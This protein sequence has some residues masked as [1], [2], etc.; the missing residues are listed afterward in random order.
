MYKHNPQSTVLD[1]FQAQDDRVIR[2]I[3]LQ[4][5]QTLE[6]K[7]GHNILHMIGIIISPIS[8]YKQCN[9]FA[10]TFKSNAV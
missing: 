2:A 5:K 9:N 8:V 4:M 1:I 7:N 6:V 3:L 10:K